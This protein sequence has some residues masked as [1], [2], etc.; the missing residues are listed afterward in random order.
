MSLTSSS[1][2]ASPKVALALGSGGARGYAHI[3]VLEVLQERG[4]DVVAVAGSSMGA[5]VGG[6]H[7][8][9]VL[10]AFA[11]WARGLTQRD[12]LRMLDPSL[13]APGAIRAEKILAQVSRLL[14]GAVI[15]DLS[16]PY[17][18]VATDLRARREVWFQQG[19]VDVAIRASIALPT[20]I[21]PVVVDGRL[22]ADGALMNPIPVAPTASVRS[23]LT[24][25]VSVSGEIAADGA[26]PPVRVVPDPPNALEELRDRV[27]RSAARVFDLELSG[28]LAELMSGARPSVPRR[29]VAGEVSGGRAWL[30][31]RPASGSGGAPGSAEQGRGFAQPP[32]GL[33]TMDVMEMS[34]D[35]MQSVVAGYRMAGYPADL[36]ITIPKAACHTLDFHRAVELVALGRQAATRALD[37]WEQGAPGA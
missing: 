23:D 33:R 35:A 13:S 31:A 4:Y 12:V 32:D 24:I 30:R 2:S 21:T 29:R 14:D 8:A 20:F 27:R 7:A 26:R 11:D 28:G 25:A 9:G 15:E 36:M 5:L 1:S 37:E 16:V 6:L 19:P 22:L 17:T 34:L 18:A 10:P 3:G